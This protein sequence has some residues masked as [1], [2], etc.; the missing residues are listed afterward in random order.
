[1]DSGVVA[2]GYMPA[3][4]RMVGGDCALISC[5]HFPLATAGGLP[6]NDIS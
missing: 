6:T 5:A 1:M 3:L 2:G 4:M